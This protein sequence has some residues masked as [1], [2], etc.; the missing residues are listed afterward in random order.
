MIVDSIP[1]TLIG[2]IELASNKGTTR[3][4][5]GNASG[6][7]STSLWY[8]LVFPDVDQ[9]CAMATT[10]TE[11]VSLSLYSGSS[12]DS[13]SC[14]AHSSNFDNQLVWQSGNGDSFYLTA[15]ASIQGEVIMNIKVSMHC[16]YSY[17]LLSLS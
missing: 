5:L 6:S 17:Q 14:V 9:G 13:L 16:H 10:F 15:A 2:N 3:A 12:C 4:S 8:K 7:N 11:G 1:T